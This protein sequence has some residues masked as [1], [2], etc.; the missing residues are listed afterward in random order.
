MSNNNED[1]EPP[2]AH[3]QHD[4]EDFLAEDDVLEVE[5]VDDQGMNVESDDEGE[6]QPHLEGEHDGEL[7][8]G[9]EHRDDA[10]AML[11]NGF[12]DSFATSTLHSAAVFCLAVHPESPNL[13]VSGGE[14][15]LAYIFNTTNGQ[16]IAKLEGHQD[17]VTSVGWNFDGTMVATGGMDGRINVWRVRSSEGP[18][19][20]REWKLLTTLEGPDEVNWIDWHPKGSLLLA[21]GADG[22]VWLWN[23]PS[24]NTLHVLSGHT[25]PVTCGRF[26]PDGKRILTASEDSTLILWDPRDGSPIHKLTGADARFRLD[27]GINCIAINPTS[28]VAILGGAEGGLRAVNLV[29]G[30]VLAAMEGHEEGAS[31]EMVAFNEVPK[32]GG[33]A[34]VTVVVS[35]GTDGRVC[36]WEASSF[37]LRSTGSHEDAVTSLAFSPHTPTFLTGS[38]DKTLKLWDYRTGSCVKTLLGNRD[39]VHTVSLSKDGKV[40]VS[41][42]EDGTVRTFRPDE[43]RPDHS[44]TE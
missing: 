41:G 19:E 22:T 30:S 11:D 28:T 12:D 27:S 25:A 29:Q 3:E 31:I 10:M 33:A 4:E 1:T 7:A 18:W 17:S 5:E 34:A 40:V 6:D 32:S 44:M 20:A 42:S 15:D 43:E 13:A 9:D 21:G 14:D 38:A 37:R 16:Q 2:L 23:L 26:T 39:I 35:V 24:G 36:T 8:D